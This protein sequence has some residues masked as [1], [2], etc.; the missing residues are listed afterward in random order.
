MAGD[1]TMFEQLNWLKIVMVTCA[2]TKIDPSAPMLRGPVRRLSRSHLEILIISIDS[3]RS[4]L[5]ILYIELVW[6][7][8]VLRL[9]R[10][11]DKDQ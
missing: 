6:N 5:S 2:V 7:G 3:A 4:V 9:R 8:Q 1:L 10:V 11:L